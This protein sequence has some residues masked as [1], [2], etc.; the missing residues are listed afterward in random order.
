L[1]PNGPTIRKAFDT[2]AM[3]LRELGVRHAFIGGIAVMQHTRVRTTDDIDVLVVVPKVALP[4]LLERLGER[5]FS[6][7]LQRNIREFLDDGLATI[8][9]ADVIV[10]LLRPVIPAMAHVVERAVTA[11]V[12]GQPVPVS[13]A[14]GLVVMKLMSMRPQDEADIRELLAAYGPDLDLDY[15]R[16]ELGTF[17][18]S[19]DLRRAK[20]ESWVRE[21]ET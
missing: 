19:D 2:L 9:F 11:E 12:L 16:A 4:G 18:Q 8:R 21:S 7:E 13:A 5:G 15:I 10:D 20:F 17:T 6:I 14:E 1:P 3:T